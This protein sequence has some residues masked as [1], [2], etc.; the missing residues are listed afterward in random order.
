[1]EN[2]DGY[3]FAETTYPA[4]SKYRIQSFPRDAFHTACIAHKTRLRN[5]LRTP[6]INMIEKAVLHQRIVNMSA[7]QGAYVE[8]QRA[9]LN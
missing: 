3:C 7:A 4:N 6:G 1:V 9:A 5:A 2:P 8:R